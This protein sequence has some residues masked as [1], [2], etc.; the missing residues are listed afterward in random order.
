M[1]RPVRM[2]TL[3]STSSRRMR[4]GEPTSSVPSGV[5][6]AALS[7][8]PAAR[9]APRRL[10]HDRVVGRAAVLQREVVA[11]ELE[12]PAPRTSGS[13]TRSA[14][15]SSSWPVSIALEHDDAQ[16]VG[17][18]AA[19]YPRR[20]RRSPSA[21]AHGAA[22]G[23]RRRRVPRAESA[24]A[25]AGPSFCRLEHVVPW[26]ISGAH[27]DAGT[28][29]AGRARGGGASGARSATRRSRR[30]TCCSCATA[31]RRGSPTGSARPST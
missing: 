22:G 23:G 18:G 12:Q 2:M 28:R 15:S 3:P 1:R 7:P 14:C 25:S 19:R 30:P 16:W 17:H 13:S 11:L 20:D 9:I 31:A 5:I 24:R 21:N 27:W 26:V 8:K 10:V 6:V 4:L 29:R